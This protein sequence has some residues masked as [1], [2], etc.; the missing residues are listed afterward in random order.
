M[1]T[2]LSNK[3]GYRPSRNVSFVEAFHKQTEKLRRNEPRSSSTQELTCMINAASPAL[4]N[5]Q[6]LST[7]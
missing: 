5:S 1:T 4:L 7:M 2:Q 3:S 6:L